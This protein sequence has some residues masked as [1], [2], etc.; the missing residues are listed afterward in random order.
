MSLDPTLYTRDWHLQDLALE[1]LE[2]GDLQP[3]EARSVQDHLVACPAC[4]ARRQAIAA[5]LAAPLPELTLEATQ[6]PVAGGGEVV[7]L[8]VR[9]ARWVFGG[10]AAMMAMAAGLVVTLLQPGAP[11]DDPEFQARG[12]ALIL[13]VYRKDD[14]GAVRVR[15]G[16]GV[17]ASDQLGFRVASQ[18][19]GYLLVFGVDSTL[20]P[21]PCYPAD[22]SRGAVAWP[23]SP[24]PV[25]LD[26]AVQLDAT[27][28]QERIVA[29]LCDEPIDLELVAPT[30]IQVVTGLESGQ[31][32]P[33]LDL[34][35]LQRE[36]RLH[37]IQ[38]AP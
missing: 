11:Q 26:A 3:H 18:D 16:D 1:R 30:L 14:A 32:L 24:T 8:P 21:Y 37:K 12:S 7:A 13:E 19:A 22:A 9:R 23:A 2:L 35:C 10:A 31:D 29:L 4:Q 27:P 33:P 17:R 25:Q 34:S 28:G 20:R 36:L 6:G 5:E 38:D 15:D